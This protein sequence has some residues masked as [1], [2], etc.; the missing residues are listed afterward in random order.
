MSVVTAMKVSVPLDACVSKARL[1]IPGR[2]H[3]WMWDGKYV[4]Y[5]LEGSKPPLACMGIGKTPQDA[6]EDTLKALEQVKACTVAVSA[7][8]GD[9][10]A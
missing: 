8:V 9:I 7:I 1:S 4:C 5:L 6:Y 3:V 2:P 10:N